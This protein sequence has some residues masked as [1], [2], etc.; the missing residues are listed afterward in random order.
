MKKPYLLG[1]VLSGALA[2][3]PA[4]AETPAMV[5]NSGA[6]FHALSQVPSRLIVLTEDQ[7]ASIKGGDVGCGSPVSV[8]V[9]VNG[10]CNKEIVLAN[11]VDT[12]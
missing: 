11:C 5:E 10:K 12:P 4:T 1:V 2:A 3:A 7:L 9:C 6:D 8:L